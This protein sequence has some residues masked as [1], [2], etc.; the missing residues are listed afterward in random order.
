MQTCVNFH[1]APTEILFFQPAT[2]LPPSNTS[3]PPT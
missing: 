1:A 3:Q 2:L